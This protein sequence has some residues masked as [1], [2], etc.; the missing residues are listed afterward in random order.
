MLEKEWGMG[1]EKGPWVEGA[2][3]HSEVVMG[4]SS[5]GERGISCV[6][7]LGKLGKGPPGKAMKGSWGERGPHPLSV[8]SPTLPELSWKALNTGYMGLRA[9]GPGR[10]RA[11]PPRLALELGAPFQPLWRDA[12]PTR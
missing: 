3:P 7:G 4:G 11:G 5:P 6:G 9:E 10:P 2:S 12:V 8:P 1:R